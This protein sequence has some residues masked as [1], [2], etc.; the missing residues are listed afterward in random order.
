MVRSLF[1]RKHEGNGSDRSGLKRVVVS[2][3]SMVTLTSMFSGTYTQKC[4]VLAAVDIDSK[5]VSEYYVHK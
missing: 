3:V 4:A 2:R 5:L 1:T